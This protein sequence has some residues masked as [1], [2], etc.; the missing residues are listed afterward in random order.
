MNKTAVGPALRHSAQHDGAAI[1][2]SFIIYLLQMHPNMLVR[3][4]MIKIMMR[5]LHKYTYS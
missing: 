1:N 3:T 5:I 2:H 4:E